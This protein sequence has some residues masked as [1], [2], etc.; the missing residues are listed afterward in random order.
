MALSS[1]Q[2][3]REM[4]PSVPAMPTM[5]ETFPVWDLRGFAQISTLEFT[6]SWNTSCTA[7]CIIVAQVESG[8]M[9]AD[10]AFINRSNRERPILQKPYS[11]R[12]LARKI[13][14]TL[15]KARLVSHR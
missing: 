9:R 7:I 5:A 1:A 4:A 10:V 14:D 8:R 15:D 13:R 6:M 12:D 3:K 2:R 11:P